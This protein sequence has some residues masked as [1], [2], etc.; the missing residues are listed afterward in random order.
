[1]S[2]TVQEA[3]RAHGLIKNLERGALLLNQENLLAVDVLGRQHHRG[4]PEVLGELARA[5]D[6]LVIVLGE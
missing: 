4:L 2:H 1:M 5:A 3:Q 6:I